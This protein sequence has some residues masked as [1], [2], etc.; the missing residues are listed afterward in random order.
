MNRAV[1]RLEG[2]LPVLDALARRLALRAEQG[3]KEGDLRRDG[4]AHR[5]AGFSATIAAT[6]NPD[7]L[8]TAVRVFLKRCKERDLSF[9]VEGIRAE[10]AIGLSAGDSK[11][12]SA[13]L[14]LLPADL[15]GMSECGLTLNVTASSDSDRTGERGA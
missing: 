13:M 6:Q 3:W 2:H 1:L 7:Q 14:T 5:S 8:V 11:Q 10:L 9:A 12:S 4:T 15:L